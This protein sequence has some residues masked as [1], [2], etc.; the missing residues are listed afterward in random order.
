MKHG[1]QYYRTL[2]QYIVPPES[3]QPVM[4]T[5]ATFWI[6]APVWLIVTV[7][8]KTLIKFLK[9]KQT[10][11]L[12]LYICCSFPFPLLFKNTFYLWVLSQSQSGTGLPTRH[13]NMPV[14][15]L[16][17]RRKLHTQ[18]KACIIQLSLFPLFSYLVFL[19]V[20]FTEQ[21]SHA[22]TETFSKFSCSDWWEVSWPDHPVSD[23]I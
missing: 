14:T 10:T 2:Y 22:H 13:Q 20:G 18:S 8:Y 7:S 16:F 5:H 17:T 4:L 15:P 9:S 21:A 6:S 1:G 12:N 11:K 23:Q 19:S 3:L